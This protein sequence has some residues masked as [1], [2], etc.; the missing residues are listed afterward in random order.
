MT[1][2]TT[3]IVVLNITPDNASGAILLHGQVT[4]AE[5]VKDEKGHWQDYPGTKRTYI[6]LNTIGECHSTFEFDSKLFDIQLSKEH[7]AQINRILDATEAQ[8]AKT[9]TLGEQYKISS[10]DQWFDVTMKTGQTWSIRPTLLKRVNS[11]DWIIQL[12]LNL[13]G[14]PKGMSRM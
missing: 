14:R 7:R 11:N 5:Q 3:R 10:Q 6:N 13:G 12:M 2:S 8:E 4:V 1:I 9:N